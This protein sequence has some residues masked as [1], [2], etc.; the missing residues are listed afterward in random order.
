MK[1]KI[2]QFVA[3]LVFSITVSSTSTA[4][5]KSPQ[6]SNWDFTVYLD[7]KKV[8]E[9]RFELSEQDGTQRLQSE[10]NFKYRFLFITAYTYEHRA[11]EQWA[12]NCLTALDAT[13]NANGKHSKVTGELDGDVFVVDGDKHERELPQCIMTFAYWNPEFLG[14]QRLLNP[15]TGEYVDVSVEKVGG[16]TLEVRGSKVSATRFKLT[17]DNI[18]VTLWYST[19]NEWLALESVAKG[20]RILRYEL[21]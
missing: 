9:H 18:D 3:V 19:E 6:L 4:N 8:G 17:A 21:S 12:G 1:N 16:E 13:T 11:A 5:G 20:G 7:N 14:Q 15:Q 10:A 2:W